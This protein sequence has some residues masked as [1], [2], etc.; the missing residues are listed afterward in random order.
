MKKILMIALALV[1]IWSAG[2]AQENRTWKKG[3]RGEV[4]VKMKVSVLKDVP[5]DN[6]E[7]STTHGYAFGEGA[8]LGVG[9][10]LNERLEIPV[11]FQAEYH[12][13]DRKVSPFVSLRGGAQLSTSQKTIF[14]GF[15]N[16]SV[17]LDMGCFYTKLGYKVLSG[18]FPVQAGT[19]NPYFQS[20]Q[21][22]AGFGIRF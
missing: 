3:Y 2:F 11:Y 21:I 1:G 17:G 9:L 8:F 5:T 14:A 13:I 15:V 16:P 10:G 6:Y 19:D 22:E 4:E 7:I 20:R 18:R 12:I